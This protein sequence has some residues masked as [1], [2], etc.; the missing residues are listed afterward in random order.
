MY[1]ASRIAASKPP[2]RLVGAV[3]FLIVFGLFVG[4]FSGEEEF[5]L[6]MLVAAAILA[7]PGMIVLAV[8]LAVGFFCLLILLTLAE[9]L[10]RLAVRLGRCLYAG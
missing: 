7:I 3:T 9:A 10:V 8:P 6:S 2:D 4:C 1:L 5:S